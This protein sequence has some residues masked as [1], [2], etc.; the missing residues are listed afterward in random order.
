ML[1]RASALELGHLRP[2]LMMKQ[3]ASLAA[4]LALAACQSSAG[5]SSAPRE[6]AKATLALPPQATLAVKSD[7]RLPAGNYLRPPVGDAGA[8]GAIV[9]DGV[10]GAT[11][12]LSGV[13]LRGTTQ[14]TPLDCNT[15]YGIV[16]RN[17]RNVTIKNGELG[18][19]KVCVA[20]VD[21]HDVTLEGITFDGWFGQRLRSTEAS[22]NL[23]DWLEPHKNDDLEWET[24]YGAAISATDCSGLVIRDC[25]GR[26]GQ[27]GILLTRTEK[28]E[29]YDND[30]SF[31][32]GWG[33]GLYR[34]SHNVVS[35]NI[36]DYCVRG[37]SHN[38]YWRGQDS[39]GILLFE[40]SS[41][42]LF[43]YNSATHSGDG[44]FLF[45]GRDTV[46]GLA[47]ERGE[48]DAGGS[49]RNTWYKND[50]RFAVANS[51][52][53]TFS[54]GNVVI[55]NRLSGSHQHGIWGGYSNNML[56]YGNEISGTLGGAITIEHGQSCVIAHNQ[57][58]RNEKGVELYWDEDPQFVD[59]PFGRQR[60]TS[61]RDHW[62]VRN[63]FQ[64]NDQDL[65]FKR[66]SGLVVGENTFAD[67]SPNFYT[68]ELRAH[69]AARVDERELRRWIR[70]S[71]GTRPSGHLSRTSLRHFSG[72][73]P[74][75][76]TRAQRFVAPEVPGS[77]ETSGR[78]E[79]G[80][81]TIIMGE[82]GPWDF[83]SGKPR[84]ER[85]RAGGLLARC[86]WDASWFAWDPESQ[87]PRGDLDAW[88]ALR[89]TPIV[90]KDVSHLR[91][92][93][94]DESVKRRVGVQ[95]FGLIASSSFTLASA[96]HY[97]L[98]VTSDDG[99]RVVIDGVVAFEDWTWHAPRQ[100]TVELELGE[101][102]HSIELE[103]FQIDGAAALTVELETAK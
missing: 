34:A 4:L 11:L 1:G 26:N 39:A 2:A 36:F 17:S 90:R 25:R 21:S 13:R 54:S 94:S 77:Q 7:R 41:D 102:E 16:V 10:D 58:E 37:Y 59:G 60:D 15:G 33:I 8:A 99:V 70:G 71:G 68:D 92:P 5:D 83:R 67:V 3:L 18:G 6:S 47:F 75:A 52:E 97:A 48:L 45:A 64:G 42:N 22:E 72:D 51:F 85:R 38:V 24:R 74:A 81:S 91:A 66:S 32:S 50:L 43:A 63:E 76:Y 27:N 86:T 14:G 98:I 30:F 79:G 88:R 31:L 56:I 9:L 87:D 23:A 93:W 55:E 40:R 29:V 46:E 78:E 82:F 103:Y 62:I 44:V 28:C 35:H 95:H 69:D 80:L 89:F 12:D 49:D 96:G 57:I 53:A 65:V 73:L 101:G 61:S 20:L 100:E 84:P 19:Y